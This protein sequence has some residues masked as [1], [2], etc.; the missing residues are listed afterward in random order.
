M[1][2]ACRV[3]ELV[4]KFDCRRLCPSVRLLASVQRA[5]SRPI[6]VQLPDRNERFSHLNFIIRWS[7]SPSPSVPRHRRAARRLA[8]AAPPPWRSSSDFRFALGQL[9]SCVPPPVVV[10]ICAWHG[11]NGLYF[12]RNVARVRRFR[13]DGG[14]PDSSPNAVAAARLMAF[15]HSPGGGTTGWLT[16]RGSGRHRPMLRAAPFETVS[17]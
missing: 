8:R 10:E 17:T 12:R 4:L 5:R 13:P 9:L 15:S 11:S 16:G 7:V 1:I 3:C 14:A 6:E 2:E